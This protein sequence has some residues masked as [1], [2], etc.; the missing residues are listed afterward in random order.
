[1]GV[2][3]YGVRCGS[4]YLNIYIP[5]KILLVYGSFFSDRQK[6]FWNVKVLTNH[7]FCFMLRRIGVGFRCCLGYSLWEFLSPVA[8]VKASPVTSEMVLF[9]FVCQPGVSEQTQG[10]LN[11]NRFL[12]WASVYEAKPYF[13]FN[14]FGR[15]FFLTWHTTHHLKKCDEYK[16]KY[17]RLRNMRIL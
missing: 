5:S 10:C 3:V 1:M 14:D 11:L 4:L 7:C 17:K 12:T 13:H 16:S 6:Y 8:F 9:N 15:T 2:S